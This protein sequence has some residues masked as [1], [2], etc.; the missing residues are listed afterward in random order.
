[1]S[2]PISNVKDIKANRHGEPEL[3]VDENFEAD[4]DQAIL[5]LDPIEEPIET[6]RS[7]EKKG[8]GRMGI[9][10][11]VLGVLLVGSIAIN[12]Q[13]AKITGALHLENERYSIALNEAVATLDQETGRAN[14][15][16]STLTDVG[17]AVDTV[18]DRIESLQQALGE[19]RIITVR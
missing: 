15:A 10:A 19:L 13:Q 4:P 17:G 5:E 7:E 11:L 3:E 6:Q 12:L 9:V 8:S 2:T 16:E 1:M 14:A 18:N